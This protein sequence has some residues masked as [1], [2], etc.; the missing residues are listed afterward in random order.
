MPANDATDRHGPRPWSGEPPSPSAAPQLY[1]GV[2]PR[3]FFAY[4]VDIVIVALLGLAL[5]FVLS[6]IGLLSFGLL[7]PLAVAVMALWP[8]IYHSYFLASGGATPDLRF[9][10]LELRDWSG[11]AIEPGQAILAVLLFYVSIALTFWLILIAVLFTDRSRTF[12]DILAGTLMVR[13]TG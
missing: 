1:A 13:K 9:I 6:I 12:H 10:G 4:L 5:A 7:S 11:K 8:L 3:R 2:L